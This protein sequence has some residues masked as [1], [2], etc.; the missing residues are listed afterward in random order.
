MKTEIKVQLWYDRT[1][2]MF[3]W[4]TQVDQPEH[5][6]HGMHASATSRDGAIAALHRSIQG[7]FMIVCALKALE[8]LDQ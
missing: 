1:R 5:L 7:E 3:P 4:H 2:G 8:E 6:M